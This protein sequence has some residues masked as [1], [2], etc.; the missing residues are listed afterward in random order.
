MML[1]HYL[2][3]WLTAPRLISGMM[4]NNNYACDIRAEN[5]ILI[6]VVG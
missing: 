1:L 3:V 5:H 6:S 4:D 2:E